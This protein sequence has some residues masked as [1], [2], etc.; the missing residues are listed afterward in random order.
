MVDAVKRLIPVIC[1]I[2][3]INVFKIVM[4]SPTII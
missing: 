2:I 3:S 1:L 4:C